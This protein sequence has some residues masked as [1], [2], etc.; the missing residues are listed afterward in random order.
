[1]QT[2]CLEDPLDEN[3]TS[4]FFRVHVTRPV[5]GHSKGIFGVQSALQSKKIFGVQS[6]CHSTIIFGVRIDALQTALQSTG[7]IGVQK[8]IAALHFCTP[9][10]LALRTPRTIT[11]SEYDQLTLQLMKI[12][13]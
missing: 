12:Q 13:Y 5:G 9:I 10:Y 7:R 6:T 2:S 11:A 1:M 8:W 3:I 4:H